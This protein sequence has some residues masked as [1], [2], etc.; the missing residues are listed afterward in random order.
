MSSLKISAYRKA[1]L[2]LAKQ[3]ALFE[4]MKTDPELRKE[5]DFVARLDEFL[6]D[7]D[8]SRSKLQQ[9]LAMQLAQPGA[10]S[11]KAGT[12]KPEAK[13]HG[14]YGERPAKIFTNPH[15]NET[16]TVK[17]LDHGTLKQW[18]AEYGSEVVDSWLQVA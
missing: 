1:E 2:A 14:P 12:P 5:L 10:V 11:H 15:T 8:M 9:I 3:I 7:N 13:K 18:I 16:I 17:R 4:Q 6:K